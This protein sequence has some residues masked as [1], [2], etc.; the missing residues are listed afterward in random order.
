M[1]E[2][3]GKHPSGLL[4]RPV[5]TLAVLAFIGLL[6]FGLVTKAPDTGIDDA[7]ASARA[8][9]AP[10]F[11]LPVL[12]PGDSGPR[13]D[14][15]VRRASA[16]GRVSLGELRGVPI[17]LNYWASWCPPCRAEAPLLETGWR[18]AQP[19]G[20]LFVGLNMQDLTDD[21]R[22]F[23][24]EFDQTYLNVRDQSNEVAVRWGVSGLPETFFIS[25]SGKVVGHVIGAI[26]EPQ[27]RQGIA[28][29]RSGR[30]TATL[31]GG[32]RQATR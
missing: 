28:A 32:A 2:P 5:A 18:R 26:S 8:L 3:S 17:V 22:A 24:D 12:Q 25:R 19:Q 15:L 4:A 30:P 1:S 10:G 23:L 11:S 16:D 13:L 14:A 20:V 27:L 29:A 9:A 31:Q 6:V 21:A 7:L